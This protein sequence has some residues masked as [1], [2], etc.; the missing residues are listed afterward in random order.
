MKEMSGSW[1]AAEL[2]HRVSQK[3]VEQALKRRAERWPTND[4]RYGWV[5]EDFADT[6]TAIEAT[7]RPVDGEPHGCARYMV[8]PTARA[9]WC[10]GAWAS[11]G[12][13]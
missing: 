11:N 8:A 12:A 10:A 3:Y 9:A 1:S 2:P 5:L 4:L 6:G 13:A 7:V